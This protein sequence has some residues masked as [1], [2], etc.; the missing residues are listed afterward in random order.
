MEK[1]EKLSE[2]L[3]PHEVFES[4]VNRT[5]RSN[6]KF[7]SFGID[8]TT[9]QNSLV[10]PFEIVTKEGLTFKDFL[11]D[12]ENLRTY[13]EVAKEKNISYSNWIDAVEKLRIFQRTTY[14]LEEPDKFDNQ[15]SLVEIFKHLLELYKNHNQPISCALVTVI[16]FAFKC[17]DEAA[18][19]QF[20]NW[21]ERTYYSNGV[22][23]EEF[24]FP[25]I[26]EA[27]LVVGEEPF[28]FLRL[29]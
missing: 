8:L 1:N 2:K 21:F 26:D 4:F 13:D 12:N 14:Q 23:K 28:V 17:K 25:I 6:R 24:Y 20:N 11:D 10:N 16:E 27:P 19:K 15:L 22:K 29:K 5:A 9:T 7:K 18:Y 3:T